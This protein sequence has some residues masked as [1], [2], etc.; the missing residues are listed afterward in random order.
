MKRTLSFVAFALS[1]IMLFSC[2]PMTGFATQIQAEQSTPTQPLI[3]YFESAF[4]RRGET[5]DVKLCIRENPGIA[6]ATISVSYDDQ[7]ELVSI[8]EDGVFEPLDF[9]AP[10]VLTNPVVFNWDTLSEEV[11]EDGMIMVLTFRVDQ[12]AD[13]ESL[14]NIDVVCKDGDV[15]NNKLETMEVT[16]VDATVRVIDYIPADINGD[17]VLNGKDVTLLRRFNANYAVDILAKAA[18]VN[19]DDVINNK[20]VTLIRR[21]L[22][23]WDVVLLPSKY[24]CNH[25]LKHV[26]AVDRTCTEDGHIEYWICSECEVVYSDVDAGNEISIR[27]TVIGANGHTPIVLPAVSPDYTNTGLTEGEY[28]GTCKDILVEQ[29]VIPALEPEYFNITYSNLCGVESPTLTRYASHLGV[30]DTEMPTLHREGY[31]FDG[32]YTA[33]EGGERV[34]DIPAGYSQNLHLYARWSKPIQYTITYRDAPINNANPSMYTVEQSV[35]LA[36]PQWQGLSFAYWTDAKGNIVDR[37]PEGTT[38]AIELTAHWR[39]VENLAIPNESDDFLVVYD[40]TSE[41]YH[42]IYKMGD[43]K[44]VVLDRLYSYKYDGSTQFKYSLERTVRVEQGAAT[45]VAQTIVHS[46]TQTNDWAETTEKVRAHSVSK[47]AEYTKCP[48]L[49]FAGIKA[50]AYEASISRNRIDMNS[51]SEIYYNGSSTEIGDEQSTS[52]S[53]ILSYVHDTSTTVKKEIV[54]DPSNSREGQ[55]N[56]VYAADIAIYAVVTYDPSNGQYYVDNYSM[57]Y[58]IFE[59]TIFEVLPEYNSVDILPNDPFTFDV[60]VDQMADYVNNSY[61]VFYDANGGDGDQMPMSTLKH[62]EDQTILPNQYV[63]DAFEFVG[64]AIEGRE[65]L[66]PDGA[67]IRD[68]CDRGET[69]TLKAQWVAIPYTLSFEE[70][71]NYSVVVE[72]IA[73]PNVGAH[74]GKLESGDVIYLGDQLQIIYVATTGHS[75]QECGATQITVTGDV[76]GSDVYAVATVNNYVIQYVANGGSG[77]MSNMTC[78]YGSSFTLDPCGFSKKGWIFA[79]WADENGNIYSDQ[80]SVSNLT[81]EKDGYVK[82]YAQ[83]ELDTVYTAN[84]GT[85]FGSLKVTSLNWKGYSMNIASLMDLEYLAQHGYKATVTVTYDIGHIAGKCK[86]YFVL[87]TGTGVSDGSLKGAVEEYESSKT[88]VNGSKPGQSYTTDKVTTQDLN[89]RGYLAIYFD[90]AGMNIF[91]AGKNSYYVNNLVVTVRFTK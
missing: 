24:V 2:V 89:S 77:E 30:K 26:E 53:S 58:D 27:D 37:I 71:I 43:I 54:L 88:T 40:E 57:V 66:I 55:Y 59:T 65:G 67:Q 10:E 56:Y 73:S 70:G 87:K 49:E 91:D 74:T 18:D 6:G 80:A 69:V 50:K 60:P 82:L 3:I 7:L 19:G 84:L 4:A 42:F 16:A 52:I 23:G 68:F 86:A 38:G 61:Y 28:C 15:F 41:R 35:M 33:I 36:A 85:Q 75:I 9:T 8:N 21:K 22:A 31:V 48:E 5:V 81:A 17:G 13:I 79:G 47:S 29:K 20:D 62:G 14:L 46:M 25:S 39:T 32:F 34:F 45:S 51:Y 83:W 12:D 44:N 72:R 76:A 63:R 64:W 78:V 90:A 1:F 11:S